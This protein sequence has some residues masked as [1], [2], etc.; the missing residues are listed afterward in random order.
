[1]ANRDIRDIYKDI[2]NKASDRLT[3]ML[4]EDFRDEYSDIL[5]QCGSGDEEL[6]AFVKAA[7]RFSALIKCIDEMRM[8]NDEFKK[9]KETIEQSIRDMKLPEAEVFEREFLPAFS[10]PLD[11]MS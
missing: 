5:R 1:Y 10:L 9:A 2:E 3:S 6:R 4:P 11:E 8:G 7:D